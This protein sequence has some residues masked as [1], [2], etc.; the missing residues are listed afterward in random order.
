[1]KNYF[2]SGIEWEMADE[3]R[4]AGEIS[5]LD[6][7]EPEQDDEDDDEGEDM[8]EIYNDAVFG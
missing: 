2:D 8:D 3:A 7:A 1:M 5:E 4:S 6:I